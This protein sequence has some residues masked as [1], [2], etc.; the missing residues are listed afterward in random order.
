[1]CVV[2]G[3]INGRN[4]FVLLQT[5]TLM[6]W[7]QMMVMMRWAVIWTIGPVIRTRKKVVHAERLGAARTME[8]RLATAQ[9]Q[10][11]KLDIFYFWNSVPIGN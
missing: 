2:D 9:N 11:G 6:R 3:G 7:I 10:E 4:V 8:K 1:M 5:P